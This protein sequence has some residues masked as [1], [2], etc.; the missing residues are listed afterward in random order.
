ML[1]R[2]HTSLSSKSKIVCPESGQY[3]R[4]ERSLFHCTNTFKIQINRVDRIQSRHDLIEIYVLPSHDIA[5]Q[6]LTWC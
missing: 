1:V 2:W 3:V 5:K 4:V 6:L